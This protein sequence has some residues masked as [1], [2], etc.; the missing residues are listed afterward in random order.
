MDQAG[1]LG[2]AFPWWLD[3]KTAKSARCSPL[4]IILR[5]LYDVLFVRSPAKC[6]RYHAC[7]K[8]IVTLL[9][10]MVRSIKAVEP[11]RS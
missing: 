7:L 11:G 1:L 6:E 10:D 4:R 5:G 3:L 2:L 8:E 9:E